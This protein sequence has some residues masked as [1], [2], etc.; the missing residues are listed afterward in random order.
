[1]ETEPTQHT[2]ATA[3]CA[4]PAGSPVPREQRYWPGDDIALLRGA[5]ERTVLTLTKI[6][7]PYEPEE[8]DYDHAEISLTNGD[9]RRAWE[10]LT[11]VRIALEETRDY[12]ENVKLCGGGTQDYEKH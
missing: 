5:L 10:A 6:S 8:E 2:A 7:F 9:C 12:A 1:M 3:G 4:P 11:N